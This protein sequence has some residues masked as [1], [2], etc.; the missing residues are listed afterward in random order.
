[1]KDRL[2]KQIPVKNTSFY[3]FLLPYSMQLFDASSGFFRNLSGIQGVV[4]ESKPRLESWL[5]YV[6]AGDLR[7]VFYSL[8]ALVYTSVNWREFLASQEFCEG[9]MRCVKV[10]NKPA[11]KQIIDECF[12]PV[13]L[14]KT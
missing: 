4:R 12:L 13:L 10:Q 14:T 9:L 3:I 11:I 2:Q 6:Q 1:M 7:E 5:C 8:Q